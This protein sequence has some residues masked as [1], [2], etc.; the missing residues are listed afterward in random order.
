MGNIGFFKSQTH[1]SD[2]S[3]M[4]WRFTSEVFSHEADFI[5]STLPTF[6][7]SL[8]GPNNFEH[9]GFCHRLYFLYR[10]I[11]FSSLFLA[12]L[13]YHVGQNLRVLLLLPIHQIGRDSPILDW[14]CFTLRIFLF[15]LFDSFLHLN[16]FL[17]SFFVKDFGF[18]ASQCLGLLGNNFS[19][20]SLL[21]PAFL[22]CVQPLSEPL[23]MQ[24]H[25]LVLWHSW[26][27]NV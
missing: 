4:L 1:G 13:F 19:L 17:E 23:L 14:L 25:I 11:P 12:L 16:F 27:L 21:L 26:L 9:F 5:D 22:L 3:F 2:K 20:P 6:A 7:L 24:L 15:V 10:H 18:D 8:S